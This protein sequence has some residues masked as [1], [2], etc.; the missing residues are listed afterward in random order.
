MSTNCNDHILLQQLRYGGVW[1]PSCKLQPKEHP[2]FI[3]G[4]L[5][6]LDFCRCEA[7]SIANIAE[8]CSCGVLAM[9]SENKVEV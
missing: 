1:W 5:C 7:N 2:S 6:V 8:V 9:V 4:L 3:G